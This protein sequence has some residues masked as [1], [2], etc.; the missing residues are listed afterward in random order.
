VGIRWY[1][2]ILAAWGRVSRTSRSSLALARMS[3]THRW[4]APPF[5][6]FSP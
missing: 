3:A 5:N 1:P 6:I 2:E 4:T